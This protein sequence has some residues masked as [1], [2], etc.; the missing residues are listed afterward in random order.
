MTQHRIE[1]ESPPAKPG[2]AGRIARMFVASKLTL[3][4]VIASILLG[5]FAVLMLAR[6]EE[7]RETR[8]YYEGGIESFVEWL[9]R[10]KTPLIRRPMAAV[11]GRR[12]GSF[13][14][15]PRSACDHSRLPPPSRAT[16]VTFRPSVCGEFF[17][18]LLI[19]TGTAGFGARR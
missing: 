13:T 9:D 10:N 12:S 19:V 16:C 8:L 6:E 11:L 17:A 3:I 14:S 5:A 4:A 15:S 18:R 7:P 2:V 1:G